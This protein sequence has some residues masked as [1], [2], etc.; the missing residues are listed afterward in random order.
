MLAALAASAL[1]L[2]RCAVLV[3]VH[4]ESMRPALRDGDR[5]LA[6]RPGPLLRWWPGRPVLVGRV[7][8]RVGGGAGDGRPPWLFVK[9][10]VAGPGETARVPRERLTPQAPVELLGG[11]W[12]DGDATWT[13][14]AGH[15][16]VKGDAPSSAD[17]VT[18]GPIPLGDVLGVVVGRVGGGGEPRAAP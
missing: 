2:R 13:V 18:W 3:T 14:P 17:S 7:P 12:R 4:G 11:T 5:V 9:R 8:E 16:F 1:A 10:R 6:I 15:V